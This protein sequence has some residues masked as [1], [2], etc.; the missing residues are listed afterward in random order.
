MAMYIAYYHASLGC[1]HL[2]T[3]LQQPKEF[4]ALANELL[5]KPRAGEYNQAIMEF[6]AIVCTPQSPDCANCVLRDSCW[7]WAHN[8]VGV[9]PAKLK[10]IK[11]KQRYF[12]YLVW[13]SADEQTLLQKR[14]GKDI[15]H[16][17]YEFPLIEPLRPS[18][19]LPLL[20]S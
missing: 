7:A 4:K 13:L 8:Q 15:W 12:N 5:D 16:G 11:I 20:S 9:L 6:G 2:S 17:L 14:E 19:L 1:R 10:K 3:P 18:L